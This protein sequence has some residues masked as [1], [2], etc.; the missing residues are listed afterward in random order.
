MFYLLF[1][2][3][4]YCFSERGYRFLLLILVLA[5]ACRVLAVGLGASARDFSYYTIFGRIDQ[6]LLGMTAAYLVRQGRL[7]RWAGKPAFLLS[8]FGLV[9]LLY[10]LNR[11]WGGWLSNGTW[12][13]LWP[14]LEGLVVVLVVVSAV[15]GGYLL[16]PSW[17]RRHLCYL[18]TVSYSI[19]LLH[20]PVLAVVQKL[21]TRPLVLGGS[22]YTGAVV[23]GV[24]SLLP[25]LFISSMTFFA[26]EAPF[27]AMRSSY[28]V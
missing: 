6:F 26:I 20:M 8:L 16:I 9:A 28:K 2:L 24:A 1:P 14:T 18:G 10:C 27:M 21:I 17:M 25:V 11:F 7:R 19:Y 12:K 13:V 4:H 22:V 5:I 15:Q 3:L 23:L